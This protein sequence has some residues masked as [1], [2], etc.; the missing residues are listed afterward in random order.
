MCSN[1]FFASRESTNPSISR[2]LKVCIKL[3]SLI[4]V[5][6]RAASYKTYLVI[7]DNIS[8]LPSPDKK[9]GF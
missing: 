3:R 6:R 7:L 4:I 2:C 5:A 9:P 8:Y 1:A